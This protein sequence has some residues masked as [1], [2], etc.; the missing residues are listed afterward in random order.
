M[1]KSKKSAPDVL[2]MIRERHEQRI[3]QN[4]EASLGLAS[5]IDWNEFSE[6]FEWYYNVEPMQYEDIGYHDF[7]MN[8]K[9]L[10]FKMQPT[11]VESTKLKD[12]LKDLKNNQS[13]RDFDSFDDD[14]DE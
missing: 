9:D 11:V 2:K 13:Q 6:H 4:H 8:L 1:R 5:D 10:W 14:Y 12:L 7:M 3:Q